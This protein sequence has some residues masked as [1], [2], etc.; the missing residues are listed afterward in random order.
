MKAGL[1]MVVA[2]ALLLSGCYESDDIVFPM[3]GGTVMPLKEG[4]YRCTSVGSAQDDLMRV[5]SLEKD[6][7]YLYTIESDGTTKKDTT[8]LAFHRIAEDRYIGVT[9]REEEGKAVPGQDIVV[10]HWDGT[11]LKT[12]NIKDEQAQELAKKYGV[13]LRS[14]TY[15]IGGPIENQR[16]FIR[17]VAVDPSAEVVQSCRPA[18]P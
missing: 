3:E 14:V 1:V 2:G 7:K 5:T 4:V 8:T 6:G 9:A 11:A 18:S 15:K 10:F 13:D 16:A 12:M 17:A